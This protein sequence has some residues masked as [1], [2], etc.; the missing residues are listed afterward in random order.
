MQGAARADFQPPRKRSRGLHELRNAASI[1]NGSPKTSQTLRNEMTS[2]IDSRASG[3]MAAASLPPWLSVVLAVLIIGGFLVRN[4]P[5]HLDDFDQAKQAFVSFEM[6]ED[7]QWFFQHTPAGNVAT[8]PPLAGWASA[9]VYELTHSWDFAWR[10][11][12]FLCALA[13]LVLLWKEGGW[14]A[15]AAF[16]LNPFSQR[17]ATLVRTDMMLALWLFLAG[18]LLGKKLSR[19][20]PWTPRERWAFF[21]VVLASM[22][23]KGPI[24]FA[25]VLP[26][27]VAFLIIKRRGEHWKDAAMWLLPLIPFA[28]WLIA[29]VLTSPEFYKQVVLT[30]F[31]ARFDS[32]ETAIHNPKPVYT[33][34]TKILPMFAPWSLVLFALPFIPTARRRIK[35]SPELLWLTCWIVGGLIVM[36]LVPS[37]RADRIFPI[38]PPACLLLA[39]TVPALPRSRIL[40]PWLAGIA[41]FANLGYTTWI[42]SQNYRSGQDG[43]VVFGRNA[44]HLADERGVT[45]SVVRGRD[46][47]MLLYAGK[48]SFT[49]PIA[50][51]DAWQKGTIGAAIMP[52]EEWSAHGEAYAGAEVLAATPGIPEKASRY[53]FVCRSVQPQR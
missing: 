7:G 22:L 3:S 9:A 33:Y 19:G 29:G 5:W 28:A 47:G 4:F 31:L 20:G 21:L 35:S 23:T 8:K 26:G 25:F 34:I 50:A 43:L 42:A 39:K 53:V 36:S 2:T 6:I 52:E 1:K 41:L 37:K 48:T 46:E 10:L 18:W 27:Y 24:I 38:I 32:G 45:L 17:L 30:E 16:G 12:C 49:N 14:L 15:A 13:L 44:R 40:I 11:P 51:R